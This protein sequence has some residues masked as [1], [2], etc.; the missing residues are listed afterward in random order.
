[1]ADGRVG[2]PP[3]ADLQHIVRWPVRLTVAVFG[4][5][6]V[7]RGSVTFAEYMKDRMAVVVFVGWQV[8]FTSKATSNVMHVASE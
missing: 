4:P 1:V 6:A 3:P 5:V 2:Y 7:Q 8:S